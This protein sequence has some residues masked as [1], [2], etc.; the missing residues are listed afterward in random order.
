L[1]NY[2]IGDRMEMYVERSQRGPTFVSDTSEFRVKARVD[3]RYWIQSST[4]TEAGQPVSPVVVLDVH[5]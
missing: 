2:L 4:T 3:G 5:T 1:S